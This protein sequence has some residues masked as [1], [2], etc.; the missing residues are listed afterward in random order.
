MKVLQLIN[1]LSPSQLVSICAEC[2]IDWDDNNPYLLEPT[3]VKDLKWFFMQ[4]VSDK[5]VTFVGTFA[6]ETGEISDP[7]I[8]ISYR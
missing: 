6:T 3:P 2:D 4:K 8:S 1:V 7:Y 5:E